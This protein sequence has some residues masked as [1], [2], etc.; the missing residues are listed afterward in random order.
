MVV[1]QTSELRPLGSLQHMTLGHHWTAVLRDCAPDRLRNPAHLARLLAVIPDALGLIRVGEPVVQALADGAF[2]GFTLLSA[3][4][5]SIHVPPSGADAF[6]DVF[7]CAPFEESVCKSAF[8][9]GFG[10][11]SA[12]TTWTVRG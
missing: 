4:H 8:V 11:V 10:A 3:S 1:L 12:E 6:V 5:A 9:A 7:S 2:V